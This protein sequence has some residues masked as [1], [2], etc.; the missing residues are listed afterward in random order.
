MPT[1]SS[2]FKRKYL[3]TVDSLHNS[4]VLI[5]WHGARAKSQ[6][7]YDTLASAGV[8]PNYKANRRKER[9]DELNPFPV[10]S[11]IVRSFRGEG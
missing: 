11:F 5:C 3:P 2:C 8:K 1:L 10:G 7:G 4:I 9:S 6:N